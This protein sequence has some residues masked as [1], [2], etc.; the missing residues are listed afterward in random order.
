MDDLKS[1]YSDELLDYAKSI[2]NKGHVEG[3]LSVEAHNPLCGDRVVFYRESLSGG[4]VKLSHDSEGCAICMAA[5]AMVCEELSGL[6]VD[7]A[8]REASDALAA[9]TAGAASSKEPWSLLSGVSK[10]PMRVKCCTMPLRAALALLGHPGGSESRI[11]L[12]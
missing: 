9:L 8:A 10:Y 2:Y 1:L 12:E 4:G 7:E 5:S 6:A 11:E 3:A